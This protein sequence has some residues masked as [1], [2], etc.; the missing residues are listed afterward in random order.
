MMAGADEPAT[1][2][3]FCQPMA[4]AMASVVGTSIQ[5]CEHE[6]RLG[7]D[8]RTAGPSRVLAMVEMDAGGREEG[9]LVVDSDSREE[10]GT[11]ME[12]GSRLGGAGSRATRR[13]EA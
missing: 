7:A 8:F 6:R 10:M 12:T 13:P 1:L 3:G 5:R 11:V 4:M 9:E 2:S